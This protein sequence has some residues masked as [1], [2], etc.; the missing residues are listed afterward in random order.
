MECTHLFYDNQPRALQRCAVPKLGTTTHQPIWIISFTLVANDSPTHMDHYIM[1]YSGARKTKTSHQPIC[2]TTNGVRIRDITFPS[3]LFIHCPQCIIYTYT[4][5]TSNF[6]KKMRILCSHSILVLPSC[7]LKT[8][9]CPLDLYQ[10]HGSILELLD[11]PVQYEKWSQLKI[12]FRLHLNHIP[13]ND[14]INIRYI[15]LK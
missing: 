15:L 14:M 4:Y 5:K 9:P 3:P 7:I 2:A 6:F 8:I 12:S 10:L 1:H 11:F 13:I